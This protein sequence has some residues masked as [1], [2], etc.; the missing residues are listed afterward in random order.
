VY[1]LCSYPISRK[2][3]IRDFPA[4]RAAPIEWT[5]ASP[6]RLMVSI[7][8]LEESRGD[9]GPISMYLIVEAASAIKVVEECHV[10]FAAPKVHISDLKVAPDFLGGG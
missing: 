5:G 9:I 10:C 4:K 2:K 3:W 7:V 8:S 6:Q 1:G